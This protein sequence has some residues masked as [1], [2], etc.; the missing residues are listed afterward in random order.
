MSNNEAPVPGRVYLA[1]VEGLWVGTEECVL[2]RIPFVPESSVREMQAEITRL[3]AIVAGLEQ[4]Q[5]ERQ[6]EDWRGRI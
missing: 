6:Q 4:Q 5:E 2:G 1:F 3:E